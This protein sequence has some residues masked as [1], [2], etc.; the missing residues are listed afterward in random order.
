MDVDLTEEDKG[1]APAAAPSIRKPDFDLPWVSCTAE[2]LTAESINYK[3]IGLWLKLS[4][5]DNWCWAELSQI[6]AAACCQSRVPSCQ[7]CFPSRL[8]EHSHLTACW[9][10]AA[11]LPLKETGRQPKQRMQLCSLLRTACRGSSTDAT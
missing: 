8:P 10:R 7:S 3:P 9:G 6:R 4:A 11:R 1:K 2:L 5:T